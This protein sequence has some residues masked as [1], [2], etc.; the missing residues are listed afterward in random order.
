M[1]SSLC[2]V[3][4]AVLVASDAAA[5]EKH[6]SKHK[7]KSFEPVAAAD[8]GGYAGRYVGVESSHWVDVNIGPEDRLE[9]SLFENGVRVPLRNIKLTGTRLAAT[10]LLPDDTQVPLDATFGERRVNDDRAFGLLVEGDV[11]LDKTTVLNRLF[12]R[13]VRST[14][15]TAP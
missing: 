11:H 13:R 6:K 15:G 1:K 7:E 2:L 3:I 8:V 5:A 14:P 10:K 12:Y 4:A 9:V